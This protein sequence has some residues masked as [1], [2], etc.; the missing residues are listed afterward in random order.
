MNSSYFT[1][2]HQLFRE[3]KRFFTKKKLYRTS[4]NG[5][6]TIERFIWKKFGDGLLWYK[7]SGVW[8]VEFRFVLHRDFLEELQRLNHLVLQLLC[9]HI[10][11]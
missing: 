6:G 2:E 5:K 11:I 7:L 9:G 4:K 1:E 10:L 8:W 3:F